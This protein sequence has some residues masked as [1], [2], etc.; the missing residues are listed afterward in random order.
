MDVL[1][2]C[3]VVKHNE[4]ANFSIIL[5]HNMVL[6]KSGA[7]PQPKVSSRTHKSSLPVVLSVGVIIAV[8]FLY[9]LEFIVNADCIYV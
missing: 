8:L 4:F 6:S 3:I 5:S 9:C 2:S 1:Y 7:G